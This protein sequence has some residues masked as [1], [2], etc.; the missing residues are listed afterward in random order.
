MHVVSFR[1]GTLRVSLESTSAAR[2]SCDGVSIV[3]E[4]ALVEQSSLSNIDRF[5]NLKFGR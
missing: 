5:P 3:L 1:F 4:T 2:T